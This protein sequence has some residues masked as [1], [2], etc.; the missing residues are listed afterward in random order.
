[1]TQVSDS[2]PRWPAWLA[3]VAR[4]FWRDPAVR[5]RAWVVCAAVFVCAYA[6]GVLGY[7]LVTPE[8]GIRCAFTPVVNHFYDEFLYPDEQKTPL[9]EGD[10]IVAV[11]G[12]PVDNWPQLLRQMHLLRGQQPAVVEGLTLEDLRYDRGGREWPFVLI[13]GQR[14]VRVLYE[15][16][17]KGTHVAWCRFGPAPLV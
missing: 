5:C 3:G 11:G 13:D 2:P 10:R 14:L 8:L 4:L 16:P 7:V 17:G 6:A 15:R 9:K 12:Q 1:M